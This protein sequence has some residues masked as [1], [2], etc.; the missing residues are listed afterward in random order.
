MKHYII[1]IFI[2]I[3]LLFLFAENPSSENY[4]LQQ[5]TISSGNDLANPPTSENYILQSSAIGNISGENQSSEN[6]ANFPGYYLGDI[7]GE[8]LAPENVTIS[9]NGGNVYLNWSPVTGANSYEVFSST[10]PNL[11]LDN[12]NSEST[13]I[14]GTTWNQPYPGDVKKFYFVKASTGV[15]SKHLPQSILQQSYQK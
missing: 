9:L 4:I 6:Y 2:A 10:D 11:P 3:S 7:I 5:S 15:G 1:L 8:I 13:G 12:W 14:L